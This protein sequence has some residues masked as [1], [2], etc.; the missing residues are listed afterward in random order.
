MKMKKNNIM[1]EI[2]I[3]KK[4]SQIYLGVLMGSFEGF[5]CPKRCPTG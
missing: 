4:S 2:D 5:G 1:L 3:L